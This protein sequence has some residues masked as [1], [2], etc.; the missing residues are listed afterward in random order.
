MDLQSLLEPHTDSPPTGADLDAAGTILTL[1]TLAK[2]GSPEQEPTWDELKAAC[3]D[4]LNKSHDLRPAVYLTAALLH[5][6]GLPGLADG[7][8][9]L[10]GMLERYWEPLFPLLDEDGDAMERSSALFNLTN[11]H[12]ILKPLRNTPLVEDRTVGRFSLQDI[13]T[14]EGKVAAPGGYD[15][16]PPQVGMIQAAFQATDTGELQSLSAAV[17]QGMED[18][19]AIEALFLERCGTEQAPDLSRL[20][21]QLQRVGVA[22]RTYMP[23][24]G[25][26][27]ADT[28]ESEASGRQASDSEMSDSQQ[29]VGPVSLSPAMA[30]DIRSRQDAVAAMEGIARY[31][32]RHEPSSPI[33]LLMERAKR[34]VDM[35][36]LSIL[37]DV[38][39]DAVAQGEKLRGDDKT[40]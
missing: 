8:H 10:R 38:A 1:D 33:P 7:L 26:A 25:R 22:L 4:A 37:R 20:K 3:R 39:P 32:R 5:T 6:D 17:A 19:A 18:I 21:E 16:D 23:E 12:K 15:G 34:L 27:T 14:A 28:E 9:L 31:F 36:F 30:G 2:W 13:E 24:G 11:F 40:E 29:A 35:D